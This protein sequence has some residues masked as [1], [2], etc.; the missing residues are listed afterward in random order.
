MIIRSIGLLIR[1]TL[2]ARC[3][4]VLG[5][6][7]PCVTRESILSLIG[8]QF[9]LAFLRLNAIFVQSWAEVHC[10]CRQT[11][12]CRRRYTLAIGKTF[13]VF[14]RK[15][16]RRAARFN[17]SFVAG[18]L[19]IGLTAYK[20]DKWHEY[21]GCYIMPDAMEN[22]LHQWLIIPLRNGLL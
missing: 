16:S 10:D 11:W 14:G 22:H 7:P 2:R 18:P 9:A 21:R 19:P 5:I 8:N 12:P 13:I 20:R 15:Y 6:Q 17:P 3:V 4:Y 1:I